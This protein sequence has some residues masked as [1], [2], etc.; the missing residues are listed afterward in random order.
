M[1][2]SPHLRAGWQTLL[3]DPRLAGL[4]A[5]SPGLP[6]YLVGG[7][8][9]DAGLG[10]PVHDLDVV[11]A[12]DGARVAER[13][14]AATGAR[15]V[16]LGGERFAA[17]RLVSG[18]RHI[19]I[20]DLRGGSL[21]ADLW[22]RDFTVNAIALAVPGGEIVD[23]TGGVEDLA[24]H[25]LRAT[26]P[27]VFAED[28]VRVLRLA[29]L[30]TTLPE[31]GVDPATVTWARAAAPRLAAAPHERVRV[32]LEILLSQPRLS[33][34]ARWWNDLDLQPLFFGKGAGTPAAASSTL[35]AAA[36][37]DRW[38]DTVDRTLP[39]SSKAS[40]VLDLA[41]ASP[42][43]TLALHW[44]LLAELFTA[45]RTA[46]AW[47]VRA[48]ARRG[49]M[50]Q[51]C[52]DLAQRLLSPGWEPPREETARRHWLHAAGPGWRDAIALRAACAGSAEEV[53]AWQRLDEELAA[54]PE[55]ARAEI[56]DPPPLLSGDDVQSLLGVA[57]GPEVGAALAQVR[58]AQV[59]GKVRNR[60]DAEAL[61]LRGREAR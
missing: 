26:R 55:T 18:A 48:L 53:D 59:A 57:P 29:R 22:R 36:R 17:L 41:A 1:T 20:W 13:L 27:E 2:E 34:A 54:L 60:A 3:A 11:V 23:P 39:R 32:E 52:R 33:A 8:V 9:R 14:A 37:L 25:R 42:Q 30:A 31:F 5:A 28:P 46:S 21:L 61:L 12:D 15:L 38:R 45:A 47:L 19:D 24:D 10:L 4:V 58:A 51:A 44:T 50:T 56:L 49:H 6:T 7:A 40:T 35:L 16:A 43:A